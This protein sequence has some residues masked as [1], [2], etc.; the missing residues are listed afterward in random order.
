MGQIVQGLLEGGVQLGV[1]SRGMGT[2][3]NKSGQQFVKSDFVLSTIDIVQDPSAHDAFV[4]GIMEGVEWI[5][6]DD[7]KY[8]QFVENKKREILNTTSK[9]IVEAQAKA[10]GDFLSLISKG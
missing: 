3:E 9:N 7:G 8:E 1:S 2:I 10:F 4:N 5:I 6:G